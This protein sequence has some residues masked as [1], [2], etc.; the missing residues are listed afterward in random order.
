METNEG[1]IVE[2]EVRQMRELLFAAANGPELPRV[3]MRALCW[4]ADRLIGELWGIVRPPVNVPPRPLNPEP[5]KKGK[6]GGHR[7][8]YDAAG[9]CSLMI[10]GKHCGALSRAAKKAAA[11]AAGG[12]SQS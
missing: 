1:E 12:G 6:G 11:L 10:V 3:Q 9:V 8:S 5:A 7:H 4:M 2:I